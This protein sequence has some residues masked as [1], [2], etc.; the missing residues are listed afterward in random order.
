LREDAISIGGADLADAETNASG[1]PFDAFRKLRETA[2]VPWHPI[3]GKRAMK[4]SADSV[5]ATT[6]GLAATAMVAG[7]AL[8][9]A[10]HAA[11]APVMS[12]HY[13]MT[14]TNPTTDQ[15]TT[16]DWH[17]TPC[18]DGCAS[19]QPWGQAR[20]INGKW[21]LDTTNNA[22]CRNGITVFQAEDAHYVWDPNTLSGTVQLT[23]KNTACGRPL[24]Y[25][26]TGNV[27]L[28]SAP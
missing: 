28:R 3:G 20:L 9:L 14:L 12:G 17:F 23:G 2:P 11:A 8:G 10:P 18:G 7:L 24:G 22:L 26:F 21:T 25:T 16:D 5:M 6:R 19:V 27:Q 1:K 4:A 13:V 15:T